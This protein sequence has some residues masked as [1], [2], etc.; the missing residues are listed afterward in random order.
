MIDYHV[1]TSLCKHAQGT[2]EAYIRKAIDIGLKDV[3]FLDHLTVRPFEKNLSMAPEEVSGYFEALQVLKHR[4]RGDIRVKIGLEIDYHPDLTDF[5]VEIVERFDFDVIGGS[6]HF[7]D[8]LNIV[9]RSSD[10]KAGRVDPDRVYPIYFEQLQTML[11][12]TYFDVVCHFDLVKKFGWKPPAPFEHAV[13]RVLSKIRQ[14]NLTV[15][16]NTSGYDHPAR[17]P[18]PSA[19]I[20]KKCREHGIRITL[21]SDAHAPDQVGRHY[22]RAIPLLLAAGYRHLTTF[23]LRQPGKI[24]I[25]HPG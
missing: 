8:D 14:R 18:Y 6:L 4:Y 22:D 16:I 11:D 12:C 3:C 24:E 15:E 10:W 5:F 7:P 19:D 1:H 9:S 2:A 21:G 25:A 23:T 13:D 20:I 17:E